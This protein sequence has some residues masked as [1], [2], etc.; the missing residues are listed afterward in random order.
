MKQKAIERLQYLCAIIPQLLREIDEETFSFKLAAHV[1]SKKEIIGNLIDSAT[2]NHQTLARFQLDLGLN[3]FYNLHNWN[4]FGYYDKISQQ[5]IIALWESQNR[6]LLEVIK[7]IPYEY[8]K[9][10]CNTGTNILTIES[11]IRNY[12]KELEGDLGRVVKY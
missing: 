9:T 5:E 7:L 8:L 4:K 12:V 1:W 10:E 11:L 6:Q 2:N 3:I